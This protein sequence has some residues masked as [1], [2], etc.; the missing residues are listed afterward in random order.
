MEL[1][2]FPTVMAGVHSHW[3]TVCCACCWWALR[4]L[5]WSGILEVH[6]DERV[7]PVSLCPGGSFRPLRTISRDRAVSASSGGATA[8]LCLRNS[9]GLPRSGE[10][11]CEICPFHC[12][13]IPN[14]RTFPQDAP[15][16]SWS[17][18]VF[19]MRPPHLGSRLIFKI[20]FSALDHNEDTSDFGF[21]LVQCLQDGVTLLGSRS[22]F[23]D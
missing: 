14:P 12:S 2:S 8:S 11:Q 18:S 6:L 4:L 19:A 15:W 1:C 10:P 21:N 7:F 22:Q 3:D 17:I 20:F 13:F 9:F 23:Y 5:R 16:H